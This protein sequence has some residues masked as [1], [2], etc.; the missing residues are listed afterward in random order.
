MPSAGKNPENGKIVGPE[1]RLRGRIS[2]ADYPTISTEPDQATPALPATGFTR[3]TLLGGAG[4]AVGAALA[5]SPPVLAISPAAA[6]TANP[7]TQTTPPDPRP[8]DTAMKR[9]AFEVREVCASNND[10]IPI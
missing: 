9:R 6:Q 10:K 8:L 3:R 5:A 7:A 2:M 4:I 1:W